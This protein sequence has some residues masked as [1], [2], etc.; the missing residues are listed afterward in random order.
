MIDP[1]LRSDAVAAARGSGVDW[2]NAWIGADPGGEVVAYPPSA[3]AAVG[4]AALEPHG[5]LR[6]TT[7]LEP[8]RGEPAHRAEMISEI[9][10]GEHLLGLLRRDDWWL[11]AGEDGYVGWVHGWTLEDDGETERAERAARWCGRYAEPLG[12]LWISDTF[13]AVPLVLGTPLLRVDADTTERGDWR[14]V[15]TVHGHEGWIPAR[16]LEATVRADARGV[17][18]HGRML[19]GTPYRWGG[20][21]PLGFDC[22]GFVQLLFALAGVG[23]PRDASQQQR[24][25]EEVTREATAWQAGDLLFFGDPAD[26]VG[27]HDGREGLLH[28]RGSVRRDRLREIA[29]LMERL[30]AVR[31]IDFGDDGSGSTLWRRRPAERRSP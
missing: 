2:K 20:R 17:L 25:G 16:S 9:R 13:A 3:A 14:L 24:V 4:V 8:M 26:H 18:R 22:S 6:P 29:P 31:R 5:P 10:G 23:L 30:S 11:V 28:C 21:S 1:A 19:T 27:I 12:T 15:A 7:I